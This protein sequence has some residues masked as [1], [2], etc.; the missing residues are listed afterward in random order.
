MSGRFDGWSAM[1]LHDTVNGVLALP[2]PG[3]TLQLPPVGPAPPMKLAVVLPCR[4]LVYQ[5]WNATVYDTPGSVAPAAIT[6]TVLE[7][8]SA[9][10]GNGPVTAL[11]TLHV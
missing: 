5:H 6:S 8:D 1:E 7:L 2:W 4:P 9:D 3:W 11:A 10:W